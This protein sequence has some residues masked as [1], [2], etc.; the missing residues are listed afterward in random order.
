MSA[1]G[2]LCCWSRSTD[3]LY[4]DDGAVF[5]MNPDDPK[6][7]SGGTAVVAQLTLKTGEGVNATI[8]IQGRAKSGPDWH[9]ES[10]I[11]LSSGGGP[12]PAPAPQP[13][14]GPCSKTLAKFCNSVGTKRPRGFF[15]P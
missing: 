1:V 8:S 12:A 13:G 3:G 7:P 4:G 5:F 2:C 14:G 6:A 9:A 10:V 11:F 15:P